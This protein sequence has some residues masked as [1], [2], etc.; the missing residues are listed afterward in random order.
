MEMGVLPIVPEGWHSADRVSDPAH[1]IISSSPFSWNRRGVHG[2]YPGFREDGRG[3]EASPIHLREEV[4]GQILGA[5]AQVASRNVRHIV[6][7]KRSGHSK[8]PAIALC[9]PVAPGL[10]LRGETVVHLQ[11]SK[12]VLLEVG[13][14]GLSGDDLHDQSEHIV[15]GTAILVATANWAV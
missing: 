9:Q 15:V 8:E 5:R 13:G 3:P 6:E 4:V 14:V 7:I 11:R 2:R 10:W 1:A 12:H